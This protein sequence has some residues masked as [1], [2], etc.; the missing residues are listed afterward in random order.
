MSAQVHDVEH[1]DGQ[2]QSGKRAFAERVS[3]AIAGMI[4]LVVVG[5]VV[6]LWLSVPPTP[7]E[8]TVVQEGAI[9]QVGASFYLPFVVTN[10]GG[11]AADAVVV[12]AEL[13]VNG[14]MVADVQQ[15][16]QFLAGGE[17][18]R[19]AFIFDRNPQEGELRLWVS[20]YRLP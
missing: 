19:G 16:F 3:T 8:L 18:E 10:N 2:A 4:L 14:E 1:Q 11:V 20:G 12:Q 17:V 6:Y 5:L 13:T 7:P 15:E 9:R